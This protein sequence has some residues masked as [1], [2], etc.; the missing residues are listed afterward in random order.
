MLTQMKSAL[1]GGDDEDGR[2]DEISPAQVKGRNSS[3]VVVVVVVGAHSAPID[4]P[5]C[6][7]GC[8]L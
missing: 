8:L 6:L 1:S 2:D 7:V 5:N 3:L 4:G